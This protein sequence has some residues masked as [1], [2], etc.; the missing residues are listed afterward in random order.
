[1]LL[2]FSESHFFFYSTG[3][4]KP[5]LQ[6]VVGIYKHMK[7][8]TYVGKLYTNIINTHS[9]NVCMPATSTEDTKMNK[10]KPFFKT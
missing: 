1:M 2:N 10:P 9:L 7:H 3:I 8:L 6:V 4:I 5:T